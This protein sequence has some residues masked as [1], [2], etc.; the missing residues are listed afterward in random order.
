MKGCAG[1][2]LV[3]DRNTNAREGRDL[4]DYGSGGSTRGF[5][6]EQHTSVSSVL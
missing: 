4:W 5:S 2:P 3:G 6:D 1:I